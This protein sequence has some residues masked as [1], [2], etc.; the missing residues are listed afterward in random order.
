MTIII[1][2]DNFVLNITNWRSTQGLTI[3]RPY[4][5]NHKGKQLNYIKKKSNN[6][7]VIIVMSMT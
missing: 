1:I 5:T 4:H 2:A 7:T 6:V 3:V